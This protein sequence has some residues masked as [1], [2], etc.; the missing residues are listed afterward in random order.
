MARKTLTEQDI[1]DVKRALRRLR[2]QHV[3]DDDWLNDRCRAGLCDC[4]ASETIV[5]STGYAEVNPDSVVQ[6]G[7]TIINVE[8]WRGR[9]PLLLMSAMEDD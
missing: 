1:K 4:F 8:R 3:A 9:D 5:L 6:H 2:L 7:E